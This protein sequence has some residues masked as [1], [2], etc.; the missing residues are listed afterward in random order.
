MDVEIDIR[1]TTTREISGDERAAFIK[2]V[3]KGGE[4]DGR[5]LVANVKSA[6]VLILGSIAG[7]VKGIAALKRPQANYRKRIG[8]KSG[9]DIGEA[10][11]PYELGYV[12]LL[13]EARGKGLSH[14]LVAKALEHVD[15]KAVFATARVD[16]K[17]MLATLAK[18]RF[19][20]IGQDYS[21]RS[22]RIRLLI[23]TADE[24]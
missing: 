5:A 13:P 22:G 9:A 16:N 1:A 15:S 14:R 7:D 4:V 17:A 11:C 12:F 2:L 10:H 18:G 23:R 19:K 6:R 21:G 20:Q 3:R 8:Q 24:P